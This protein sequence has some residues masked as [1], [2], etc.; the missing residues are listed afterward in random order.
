MVFHVHLQ[1]I[2]QTEIKS[3]SI[4]NLTH[5]SLKASLDGKNVYIVLYTNMRLSFVV[6]FSYSIPFRFVFMEWK[7]ESL[8][9]F[10]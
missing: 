2:F 9:K 5:Q 3:P 10:L 1:K 8:I 7:V 4:R 6:F